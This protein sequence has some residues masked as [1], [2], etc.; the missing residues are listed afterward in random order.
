[1]KT[2][3]QWNNDELERRYFVPLWGR[4]LMP[5]PEGSFLKNSRRHKLTPT[6]ERTA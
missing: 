4:F 6:R 3:V 5:F 2:Q 1:M